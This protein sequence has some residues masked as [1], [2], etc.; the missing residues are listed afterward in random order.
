MRICPICGCGDKKILFSVNFSTGNIGKLPTENKIVIC[1]KC[2][3]A[4]A[5]ND[6]TQ[7][8]YDDY[9]KNEN[10]YAY[11]RAIKVL[12]N[13]EPAALA[14]IKK[15]I[16]TQS[17]II[18][19][20]FGDGNLLAWLKESGYGELIGMDPDLASCNVLA[21]MGIRAI[22][23]S[24]FDP[25]TEKY[26]GQFGAAVSTCVA[27]HIYDLHEYIECCLSLIKAGGR[28][29][30]E[31]PAVEGFAEHYTQL[32]NYFN[33]EHI[34]YFSKNTLDRLMAENGF[35]R[36]NTDDEIYFTQT[37]GELFLIGVYEKAE[38]VSIPFCTLTGQ[39][40]ESYY[41]EH[42][43]RQRELDERIRRFMEM[44]KRVVV[45]GCGSF[46]MQFFARNGELLKYVDYMIDGNEA[47]QAT[48]FCG[49]KV[50]EVEH[51]F[52][53]PLPV[54]IFSMLGSKDC[55]EMLKRR[56]FGLPYCSI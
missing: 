2:G 39:S 25:A 35:K 33:H 4:F 53:E 24:I 17:S 14:T 1:K 11:D 3:F 18:D 31:V 7:D 40:I 48:D 45:W 9:Y 37:N 6:A 22:N 55:I 32:P 16:D 30:I 36:I 10:V 47:K 52:S 34:N 29:V 20:G 42:E 44:N 50:Y 12:G 19:I 27:E 49:K 21:E 43:K 38:T 23:Q 13:E 28:F 15:Y 54:L 26:L 51:L 8:L 5:D 41:R 56:E 46:A